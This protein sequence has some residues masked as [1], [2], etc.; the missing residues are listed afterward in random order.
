MTKR[1]LYLFILLQVLFSACSKP[2]VNQPQG[3]EP[4]AGEMEPLTV[5][6]YNVLKPAGRRT[7]MS[8]HNSTVLKTLAKAISETKAD[9]IGFN[10]LDESFIAGADFSL[11][12]ACK[13]IKDYNWDIQW[14]N[15]IK[16]DG[17][18]KYSYANGFAYNK[19]KLKVEDCGY[20]W[21]SK[22]ENEWYVKPSSAYLKAG[23]PERT[24]IW[25]KMTHIASKTQFWVFITH[26]PTSSQGGAANMAYVVNNFAKSKAKDAPSILLGDMNS[27]PGSYAYRLLC[28]YWRDGNVNNW[29]TMSGS[30]TNY[31]YPVEEY[32]PDNP[33]ARIDHIMTRGCEAKD[34]RLIKTSYTGPDGNLWC[35][36]DHLPVVAT[37]TIEQN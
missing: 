6:T 33:G 27:T 18:I 28:R 5:A 7:E 4:Q 31:Y 30:S 26:L 24:C 13:S 16:E 1:F 21:L 2:D 10:E 20:V 3:E 37:V 23:S 22:E 12:A 25:I 36:S 9:I 29:G 8:M 35:P 14:P 17:S 34:Y 11:P 15:D 19:K 32:S